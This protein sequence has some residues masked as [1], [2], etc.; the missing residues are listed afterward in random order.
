MTATSTFEV[1][2]KSRNVHT[3][4]MQADASDWEQ[5]FLLTGDRHIDNGESD[6]ALQIRHLKQAQERGAGIIDVGDVMD[7]MQGRNDPRP[8]PFIRRGSLRPCIRSITSP[9]SMIPAPRSCACLRCRICS[10][11]SLSLLSMCRSPVSRNHCS[12][13]EASACIVTVW[14][15]RDFAATSKVLVFIASPVTAIGPA[16]TSPAAASTLRR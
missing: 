8:T 3:V 11:W 9:T 14:T 6:H 16:D 12:Q 15:L 1:A 5:W 13:S 4:T 10:A 7:L 2:A